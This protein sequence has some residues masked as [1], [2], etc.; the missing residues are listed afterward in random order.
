MKFVGLNPFKQTF[1]ITE[2][3]DNSASI[4]LHNDADLR[5][6]TVDLVNNEVRFVWTVKQQALTLPESAETGE[7]PTCGGVSL[8][9]SGLRQL[10]TV[11][12]LAGS[13]EAEAGDLDILEYQ[14]VGQNLGEVRL[15][16]MNRS[17]IELV[18]ERCEMRRISV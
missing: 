3:G 6:F 5:E 17:E 2:I 15:S 7:R 16:F 11:G 14:L 4:D 13:G 10:R 12:M 9:F 18:A 8:I 1:P